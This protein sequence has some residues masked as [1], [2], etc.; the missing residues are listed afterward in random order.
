M[1]DH[2]WWRR[3]ATERP[4]VSVAEVY[5]IA[6]AVGSRWRALVLLAAFSGLRFGELA[7]LTG[8]RLDL[9]QGRVV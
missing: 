1:H 5:A 2:R 3:N 7:A 4:A 9:N 8:D 6:D